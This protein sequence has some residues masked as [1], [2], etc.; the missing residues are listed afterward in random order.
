MDEHFGGK[1]EGS[2]S[3]LKY[4]SRPPTLFPGY[5]KHPTIIYNPGTVQRDGLGS[6]QLGKELGGNSGR[7]RQRTERRNFGWCC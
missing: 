4:M 6:A 5:A 2:L 7:R 1:F 3:G